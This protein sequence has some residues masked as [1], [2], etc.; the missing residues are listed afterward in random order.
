MAGMI[1]EIY[2]RWPDTTVILST[3]V[4]SG[5][6]NASIVSCTAAVSQEYRQLVYNKYRGYRITLAN[7]HDAI[8]LNQIADGIHPN[9]DG[10]RLFAAVWAAAIDRVARKIKPPVNDGTVDDTQTGGSNGNTCKKVAGNAKGPFRTQQGSGE[11][12]GNYVHNRV[13]RGSIATISKDILPQGAAG[14]V[15]DYVYFANIVKGDPNAPRDA[16]L[17]DMIIAKP[18]PDRSINWVFRQNL[19]SGGSFSTDRDL[20]VDSNCSSENSE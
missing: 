19:G 11:D 15:P 5:S 9:D 20:D 12:D 4:R 1:D 8:Q 14:T 10:Y 6:T 3:L 13:E 2:Q 7:I 16:S 17:D 18:N